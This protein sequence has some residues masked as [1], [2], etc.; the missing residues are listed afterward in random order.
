MSAAP[1]SDRLFRCPGPT[2]GVSGWRSDRRPGTRACRPDRGSR[3]RSLAAFFEGAA[4]APASA[5][6]RAEVDRDAQSA[7]L[8]ELRFRVFLPTGL[9][10][11]PPRA[12]EVLGVPDDWGRRWRQERDWILQPVANLTK[13]LHVPGISVGGGT[14]DVDAGSRGGVVDEELAGRGDRDAATGPLPGVRIGVGLRLIDL[15][16]EPPGRRIRRSRLRP[17]SRSSRRC[18]RPA[19]RWTGRPRPA[20]RRSFSRPRCRRR[21]RSSTRGHSRRAFSD[22]RIHR[23]HRGRWSPRPEK[24]TGIA[25]RVELGDHVDRLRS[26]RSGCRWVDSGGLRV[27]AGGNR[28]LSQERVRGLGRPTAPAGRRER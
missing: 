23:G 25:A 13:E 3:N 16:P 11:P 21:S 8:P 27:V 10:R 9:G 24:S 6:G 7:R 14:V 20:C 28:E 15:P 18:S 4:V 1:K 2:P 19:G 12:V 22:S 17:A 5:L 26:R